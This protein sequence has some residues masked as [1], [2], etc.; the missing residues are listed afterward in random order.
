M[1]NTPFTI[2]EG[3]P[4]TNRLD[5]MTTEQARWA[6]RNG[7]TWIAYL[8]E[9]RASGVDVELIAGEAKPTHKPLT[10]A[11]KYAAICATLENVWRALTDGLKGQPLPVN[12]IRDWV[13]VLQWA[14]KEI[15]VGYE[16]QRDRLQE[17]LRT[18]QTLLTH[19]NNNGGT[20]EQIPE[21]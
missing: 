5:K 14:V 3:M 6:I 17:G 16:R 12:Q 7:G 8:K 21:L 20:H 15:P 10:S 4:L 19:L 13:E 2:P 11:E 1:R 9:Q 18:Y